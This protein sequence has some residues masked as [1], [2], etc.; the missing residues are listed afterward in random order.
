MIGF[1][2]ISQ[3]AIGEQVADAGDVL[4]LVPAAI[5]ATASKSAPSIV[6]GASVFPDGIAPTATAAAPTIYV[7]TQIVV[8][9]K[10]ATA[11]I[12]AGSVQISATVTVPGKASSA[13]LLAP[14]INS[15][16]A[17]QVPSAIAA[18]ASRTAPF[19]ATGKS[20]FPPGL[21]AIATPGAPGISIGATLYP[22]GLSATSSLAAPQVFVGNYIEVSN[23]VTMVTPYGEIGSSSIGQFSI[24]EGELSTRVVKI[25]IIAQV[26]LDPPFITAGK[27]IFPPALNATATPSRPE[28][29]SRD[30]KLR[31]LAI[32]S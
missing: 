26:S 6:A 24:G 8:P 14:V 25:G 30:R 20:I 31:I 32:A 10:A 2:S 4:I 13:A 28:I 17:I 27:S 15:G 18:T 19:I 7:G 29:D 21:A 9:A 1:D 23:T 11:S 5:S 3:G 22:P 12:I 16:V